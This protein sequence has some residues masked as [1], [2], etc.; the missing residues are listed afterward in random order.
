[1]DFVTN[2]RFRSSILCKS[3]Q[4]INRGLKNEQIM[5]YFLTVNPVMEVI[6]T[7]AKKDVTF[8]VNNG[9]FTT[10]DAVSG[11][12]F[13]ELAASK[14]KPVAAKEL[15][16]RVQKKLGLADAKQIQAVLVSQGLQ[17]VLRGYLNLHSD[18]LN[19]VTE[20]SEKPVAFPLARHEAGIN[21]C[22][23][24]TNVLSNTLPSDVLAN[25]IIKN[26][27]GSKTKQ[28]VLNLLVENI[29]KGVLKMEKNGAAVKDEKL[30]RQDMAKVLDEVLQ[31]L[32]KH[33]LLVA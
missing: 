22:R 29:Q 20:V 18:S 14:Q 30:I 33:A 9:S 17:L 8:K 12:L 23:T 10:H 7:D 21:N 32:A 27:D 25:T 3:G 1:M 2:R 16:A 19:F 11:T 6:G 4:K 24:V 5:N 15:V 28:D 31:R 26:L 13:M